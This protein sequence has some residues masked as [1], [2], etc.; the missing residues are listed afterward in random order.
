[1]LRRFGREVEPA[2]VGRVAVIPRIGVERGILMVPIYGAVI[3]VRA[4]LADDVDLAA[5]GTP[6]R[7][8]VIGDSNSELRNVFHADGNDRRLVTAT[9]DDVVRDVDAVEIENVLVAARA[10]NR[11]AAVRQNRRHYCSQRA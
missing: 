5:L 7:S 3:F 4:A 8:I 9:C 2:A 6:E 1:M 11:A 10:G